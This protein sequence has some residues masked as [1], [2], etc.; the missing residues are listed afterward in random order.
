MET[1]HR[2]VP[3][4]KLRRRIRP[5]TLASVAAAAVLLAPAVANAQTTIP[6]L[7]AIAVTVNLTFATPAGVTGYRV[8]AICKNVPGTPTGDLTLSIAFGSQGG[9]GQ[10]LAPLGATVS[11]AFR[12][13]VLGN[14]PRPLAGNAIVVGGVNRAVSFIS[15]LDG[16]VVDPE[17]VIQTEPI[18]ITAATTVLIGPL[19]TTTTTT[20]T[21]T[22]ATTSTVAPT[23]ATT[24]TTTRSPTTQPTTSTSTTS[25]L[26]AATAV[27]TAVLTAVPTTVRKVVLRRV[28]VKV[29]AKR[30]VAYKTV[31]V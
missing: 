19:P 17:T 12:V 30:C 5:F 1:T 21:T 13:A 7:Q 6:P 9:S 15:T 10:F 23:T 18:P 26:K 8:D 29:R 28:C 27:V 11:C 25:T 22:T 16:V 2:S 24:T 20:A 3:R 31:R 14:G 4:Q